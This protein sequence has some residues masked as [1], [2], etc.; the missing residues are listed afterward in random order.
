[1]GHFYLN[2]GITEKAERVYSK[3]GMFKRDR[4]RRAAPEKH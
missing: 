4:N 3:K 1:M 2:F